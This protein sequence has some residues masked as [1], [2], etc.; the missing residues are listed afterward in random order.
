MRSLFL[1]LLMIFVGVS[2][3]SAVSPDEEA[4]ASSKAWVSLIDKGQY[5]D[6]WAQASSLFQSRVSQQKW[7]EEVRSVRDPFDAVKSR[8]VLKVNLTKSLPGVPD[9]QYAVV[10]FQTGFANKPQAVETVTMMLEDD[11]WRAAGYFI[12]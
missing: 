5:A 11:H 12:N 1:G 2:A 8:Q 3:A 6:S 4:L 10:I 9:G 7:E